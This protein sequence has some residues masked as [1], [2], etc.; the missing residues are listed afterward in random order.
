MNFPPVVNTRRPRTIPQPDMQFLKGYIPER[1]STGRRRMDY[2]W[3]KIARRYA[4]YLS[5]QPLTPSV[6]QLSKAGKQ[7]AMFCRI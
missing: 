4:E 1:H 6:K 3:G 2:L 7:R 5:V